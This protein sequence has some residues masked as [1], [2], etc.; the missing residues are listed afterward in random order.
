MTRPKPKPKCTVDAVKA[1]YLKELA[2]RPDG[3]KPI[4]IVKV[5]ISAYQGYTNADAAASPAVIESAD[6]SGFRRGTQAAIDR[7]LFNAN[8]WLNAYEDRI[9]AASDPADAD[10]LL[11]AVTVWSTHTLKLNTLGSDE[12]IA[13][14]ERFCPPFATNN[15]KGADAGQGRGK[16]PIAEFES[17][18]KMAATRHPARSEALQ[19]I[20]SDMQA[21]A[22]AYAAVPSASA[23]DS[24]FAILPAWC[25][26]DTIPLV[27]GGWWEDADVMAF[28]ADALKKRFIELGYGEAPCQYFHDSLLESIDAYQR[29]VT[30]SASPLAKLAIP[31]L[32]K[33]IHGAREASPNYEADGY[34]DP[35]PAWLIA[36]EQLVWNTLVC[37]LYG[38]SSARPLLAPLPE[39]I[40]RTSKGS[41]GR[42]DVITGLAKTSFK[43]YSADRAASGT[44]RGYESFNDQPQDLRNSS[45]EHIKS[46]PGK[47]DVLGYEIVPDGSCYPDQKITAFTP[48]EIECL[49]V[50]E[51]RRWINERTKAGWTLGAERDVE[52]KT[53]PYLVPWEE[54]P[55]RAREWNR[56]AIRNI[57]ML[58]ASEYL[59]IARK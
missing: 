29:D 59:A 39:F 28:L 13:T 48:S 23:L 52:R 19:D 1:A 26:Q 9:V 14:F 55:D 49:A 17:Q 18:V 21:E 53:S 25:L 41:E 45:I 24:L 22:E 46:I 31:E 2:K 3:L 40:A 38:P 27:T 33:I 32:L 6:R 57:P 56:S 47:L 4:E 10:A 54:L 34:G 30:S 51:H 43:R 15:R 8:Y 58:L 5:V 36:K 12:T 11:K 50:L 44:E 7:L 20:L 35:I 16:G 42:T 37:S